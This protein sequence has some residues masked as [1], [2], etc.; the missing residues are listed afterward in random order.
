MRQK[1][2]F[3]TLL[4]AEAVS[5]TGS[6][7]T[8]LSIFSLLVFQGDAG[9]TE[10]SV[11]LLAGML[12]HLLISPVAGSL[13]DRVDRRRLMYLSQLAHAACVVGLIFARNETLL[14]LLLALGA[15]SAALGG[16]ARQASIPTLVPREGL[17]RANALLQQVSA[18]S[19]MAG[20]F[21]A[22]ALLA[23]L[24]PRQAMWLD[25]ASFLVA[26]AL[27][28]RLPALLPE[29]QPRDADPADQKDASRFSALLRRVV[30]TR[31]RL[32][33]L[34]V[35]VFVCVSVVV[36]YDVLA[37]VAVRDSIGGGD[38]TYGVLVGSVGLGSA[39]SSLVLAVRGS[40]SPWR[41]VFVGIAL[42]AIVPGSLAAAI[43]T[44]DPHVGRWV[45]IAGALIGGLGNGLLV[46][47]LSTLVQ[48]LSPP[49]LLGRLTGVLQATIIAA[50][51]TAIVATPLWI[52]HSLS[53]GAYGVAAAGV[54]LA[55]S[56]V[57]WVVLQTLGGT[58]VGLAQSKPADSYP[59]TERSLEGTS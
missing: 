10:T 14:Y 32:I 15:A 9:V 28:A 52:P 12:P 7:I 25:V 54:T 40:K 8:T 18:W 27:L 43:A 45:A 19:K 58:D 20:P 59:P 56:V 13:A 50:Q 51:L 44:S 31:P 38:S 26:A 24:S 21:I 2:A 30:R 1:R 6:W 48:M 16:P 23:I 11:V 49:E 29:Q 55:T 46:T 33:L 37:P 57:G 39:I 34:L 41:D 5:S 47:Q 35:V 4:F 17:V 42:I 53:L 22:G 36:G 3:L